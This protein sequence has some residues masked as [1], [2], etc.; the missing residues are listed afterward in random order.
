MN[1]ISALIKRTQRALS[2]LPRC[3]DTPARQL[4][5]NQVQAPTRHQIGGCLDLRLL[6]TVRKKFRLFISHPVCGIS[7][8]KTEWTKTMF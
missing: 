7:L 6:R 5:V 3:E 8:E 1:E 4:P 2:P